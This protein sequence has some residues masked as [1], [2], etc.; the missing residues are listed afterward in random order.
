[1]YSGSGCLLSVY[2]TV[3]LIRL[4]GTLSCFHLWT[5]WYSFGSVFCVGIMCAMSPGNLLRITSIGV[6]ISG[7]VCFIFGR[8]F[9]CYN[10]AGLSD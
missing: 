10:S 7:L 1:M 6:D 4:R 8:V 9:L 2:H 5:C 3:F